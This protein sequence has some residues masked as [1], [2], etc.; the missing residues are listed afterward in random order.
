MDMDLEDRPAAVV[1]IRYEFRDQLVRMGVLSPA[2][3]PLTRRERARG[4]SG[5]Y[6]PDPSGGR[7]IRA[8][9]NQ[10]HAGDRG[11]AGNMAAPPSQTHGGRRPAS[12]TRGWECAEGSA[13]LA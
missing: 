8:R 12:D 13:G 4:F 5:G 2:P 1:R 10:P 7:W 3:D 11:A 6:C 9:G